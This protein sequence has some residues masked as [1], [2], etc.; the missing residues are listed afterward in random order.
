MKLEIKRTH[1]KII[2]QSP[3]DE[4]WIEEVL[5][6]RNEGDSVKLKRSNVYGTGSLAYIEAENPVQETP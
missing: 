6:L 5:D 1:L 3:Q 4:A 2:P